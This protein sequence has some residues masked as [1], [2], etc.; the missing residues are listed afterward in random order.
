MSLKSIVYKVSE[1]RKQDLIFLATNSRS[2]KI[3][4]TY[5]PGCQLILTTINAENK[6]LTVK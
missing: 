5:Y 3:E 2:I 4:G 1:K 6:L